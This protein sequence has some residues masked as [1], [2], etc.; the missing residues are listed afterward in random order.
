MLLGLLILGEQSREL[1]VPGRTAGPIPAS[2]STPPLTIRVISYNILFGAGADRQYDDILSPEWRHKNRLPGLMSFFQLVKPDILGI[3]EANGWNRGTPTV[4]RQVAE[5]LDMNYYLAEA[6]DDFHVVLLTKFRIVAA[7]TL[8]G[9]EGNTTFETMRALRATLLTPG[10]QTLHVFV[11]HLDPFSTEIRQY[12]IE[13]LIDQMEPYQEQIA[14]LLGDMN[15][16]VG[17]PEYTTLRQTGWRHVALATDIDQIWISPA[18]SWASEPILLFGSFAVN[19]RDMSDHLPAG[20]E[21]HL[22]PTPVPAP[23]PHRYS[24]GPDC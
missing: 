21:I 1:P 14:I 5:Q 11:A 19:F 13:A 20:A 3:Q 15:F 8:S 12:Q 22:Y 10:G 16:C 9:T 23:D 7:E 18:A 2:T 4:A 17:S 24:P 6:P